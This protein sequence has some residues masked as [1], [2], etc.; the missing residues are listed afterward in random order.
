MRGGLT[1][2]GVFERLD[3]GPGVERL[4][5]GVWWLRLGWYPPLCQNAYLVDD[6]TVTLVDAGL[7]WDAGRLRR[8]LDAAGYAVDDVDRV[9]VTH[10]DL[11]HVGGAMALADELDAP[12]YVGAADLELA[13]GAQSPPLVHHKGA[14]H[15][16]LRR[17]YPL[18][19]PLDVES[20]ADGDVVGG[21]E[22]FVTPGHNPGHV[23]WVHDGLGAAFLGD[24]VW[25][26]DGGLTT[27]IRLDS[28]DMA[29][30]ADSVRELDARVGR[31]DLACMG[32]GRP[33][34]DGGAAALS[35][36]A[37]RL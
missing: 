22:A 19:G 23:V 7:P 31:F 25:A 36:L 14:F 9:L 20:V 29:T 28:Y 11:D 30:L 6:G 3:R 24:L 2:A 17:L 35:A 26:D 13:S 8:Y 33:L 18:P 15:R 16:A 34:T 12:A 37:D 4:A 21:F 10:Y 32:H 1:D 5:E 27:P